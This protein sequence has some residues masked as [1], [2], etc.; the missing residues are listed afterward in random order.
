MPRELSRWINEHEFPG[1]YYR[2]PG[3]LSIQWLTNRVLYHRSWLIRSTVSRSLKKFRSGFA[4]LDAGC[5]AGDFLVP[6]A[7]KFKNGSFYG[8]DK[9]AANIRTLN[10][11]CTHK[12]VANVILS[13]GYLQ[14]M[15]T[16]PRFSVVLCAS[17]LH[18]LPSRLP[19]LEKLAGSMIAGGQLIIYVPVNYRRRLPGYEWLRETVFRDVDYEGGKSVMM[20]LSYEKLC[21]ELTGSGFTVDL[22]RQLYGMAGQIAYEITSMALL[23]IQKVPWVLAVVGTLIYFPLIHPFVLIFQAVDFFSRNKRGNGLLMMATRK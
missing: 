14:E 17:V 7:R 9:S 1:V 23:F 22:H 19:V 18:Y 5:G 6:L 2:F 4:Y 13:T 12:G 8:L 15:G 11:Y 21:R 10:R 3:L 20:D 16:G